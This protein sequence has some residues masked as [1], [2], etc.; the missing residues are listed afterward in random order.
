MITLS[1]VRKAYRFSGRESLVLR[2]IDFR[3]PER[4][5]V[6][7]VGDSGSGKTTL[8]NILGGLDR[9]YE[10]TIARISRKATVEN[11]VSYL[12][13]TVEFE[14]DDQ[15]RDG[16]SA[17]IRLIRQQELGVPALP[18]EAVSY[19]DDNSAFVYIR[20]DAGKVVTQPVTLG[21]TDGTWVQVTDGVKA[22]DTVL[23]IYTPSYADLMMMTAGQGE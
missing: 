11:E 18:S 5:L 13:A 7:I 14:A 10:G 6:A 3:L 22:G 19:N 4:G 2:D 8:L 23:Y 20:D 1:H 21:A 17:E 16:L 15:V 9:D 12:D